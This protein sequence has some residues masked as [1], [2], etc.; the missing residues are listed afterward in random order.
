MKKMKN[1]T[2]KSPTLAQNTAPSVLSDSEYRGNLKS[3]NILNS[4]IILMNR[5]S[6]MTNGKKNGRIAAKSTSIMGDRINRSRE[7][8]EFL[9]FGFRWQT[10]ILIIY[11]TVKTVMAKILKGVKKYQ[12]LSNSES[13]VSRMTTN[14]LSKINATIKY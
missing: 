1:A 4:L 9:Y 10:D 7:N 13:S 11:S 2:T 12:Y 6:D 3:A 8:F 14:T 5:V